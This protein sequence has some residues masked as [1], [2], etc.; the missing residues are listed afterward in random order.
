MA[1]ENTE[2][3]PELVVFAGPN[4]SGKS[5]FTTPEWIVGSYINADDIKRTTLC[6]DLQAAEKADE[7]REE[8]LKAKE[9]FTFETVLST[10]SKL[11]FMKRAKES[12][13]F[14][15]GYF[16][17]TQSPLINIKRIQN[18]VEKGLHAVPHEKVCS[19]YVRSLDNLP[20][21]IEL[22]D[23]C[24][25][26]DNSVQPTRIFRK[27]KEHE[28]IYTSKYWTKSKLIRLVYGSEE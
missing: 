15:R 2:R 17:L 16:V 4:G 12:G 3:K 18:R 22:C 10:D 26:Y 28:T 14:I 27:H 19:R 23:I 21:F 1:A 25:V 20:A 7:L 11:K 13:Y 24:H 6:T 8:R 5:T 9:D